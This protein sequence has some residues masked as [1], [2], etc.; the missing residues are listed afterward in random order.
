[1]R[2][3]KYLISAHGAVQLYQLGPGFARV[4]VS[5]DITNDSW[6]DAEIGC[7]KLHAF[8]LKRLRTS[9]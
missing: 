3:T 5:S 1:M 9:H 6:D 4:M 7:P 2:L 8:W